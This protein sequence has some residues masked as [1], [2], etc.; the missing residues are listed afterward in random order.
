LQPIPEKSA[1]HQ[2]E[3]FVSGHLEVAS[4]TEALDQDLTSR[5][6]VVAFAGLHQTNNASLDF[7]LNIRSWH[8]SRTVTHGLRDGHFAFGVNPHREQPS[9][10]SRRQW[11]LRSLGSTFIDER[12]TTP[13][14]AMTW[15]RPQFG[16]LVFISGQTD[17]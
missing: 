6:F 16:P 17:R 4:S 11:P 14:H 15:Q 8:K 10:Y 7:E 9:Y 2:S 3:H 1:A 13:Q 5:F 12:L